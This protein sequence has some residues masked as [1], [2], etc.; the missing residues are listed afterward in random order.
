M[1]HRHEREFDLAGHRF[2][3]IKTE[4]LLLVVIFGRN[5]PG[6]EELKWER[7]VEAR[8]PGR[9]RSGPSPLVGRPVDVLLSRE[10]HHVL[11]G[12]ALPT[13]YHR[14]GDEE[15]RPDRS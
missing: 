13:S 3:H 7:G 9:V 8:R 5:A 2:L 6:P 12:R 14:G 4:P 11:R 10:V 1:T 15:T